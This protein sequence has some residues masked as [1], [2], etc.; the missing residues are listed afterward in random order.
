M[1]SARRPGSS[2]LVAMT[3]TSGEMGLPR[4]ADFSSAAF[5]LRI[6]A[7]TSRLPFSVT[8][9]SATASMR[10]WRKAVALLEGGDAGA[11]D[12]LHEHADAAVGQLQHAHDE[13]DRARR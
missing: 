3:M 12:A 11:A 10:A 8:S 13:G 9:G 2:M 1:R 6:R 7:S 5:T 4:F